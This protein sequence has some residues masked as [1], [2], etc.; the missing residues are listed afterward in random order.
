MSV[1]CSCDFYRSKD[2]FQCTFTILQ[3]TANTMQMCMCE[4]A[5]CPCSYWI[6]TISTNTKSCFS[7]QKYKSLATHTNFYLNSSN[8]AHQ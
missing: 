7:A 1:C 4:D 5:V 8:K 3:Y 6:Y 2:S